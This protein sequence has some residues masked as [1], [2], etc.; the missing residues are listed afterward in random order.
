MLTLFSRISDVLEVLSV[1][2]TSLLK[3]EFARFLFVVFEEGGISTTEPDDEVSFNDTQQYEVTWNKISLSFRAERT[4]DYEMDADC[5][6]ACEEI[7]RQ[8]AE[9]RANKA[10]AEVERQIEYDLNTLNTAFYTLF[11]NY[12]EAQEK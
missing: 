8:E 12:W 10:I 4:D 2:N 3:D 1:S 5:I 11:P 7:S 9:E 6:E